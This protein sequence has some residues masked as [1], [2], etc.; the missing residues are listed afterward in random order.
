M[1]GAVNAPNMMQYATGGPIGYNTLDLTDL[2]KENNLMDNSRLMNYNLIGTDKFDNG[3]M[4]QAP[5]QMSL[6]DQY[7]LFYNAKPVAKYFSGAM[8]PH[9]KDGSMDPRGTVI[10]SIDPQTGE[11]VPINVELDEGKWKLPDGSNFI[12]TAA[13][14][15]EALEADAN[16][17][18]IRKASIF[19]TIQK[20]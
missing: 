11:R 18:G 6:K 16:N 20:K 12:T 10:G 17:D 14:T 15:K 3:G 19:N 8:V 1:G 2:S 9:P 5:S 4:P 13:K 7:N